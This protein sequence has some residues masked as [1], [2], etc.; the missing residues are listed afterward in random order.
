MDPTSLSNAQLPTLIT[1][2]MGLSLALRKQ[3]SPFLDKL[4]IELRRL[5]YRY[6]LFNPILGTKEGLAVSRY[7]LFPAILRTCKQINTEGREV[8]Y[9]D[10]AFFAS[11]NVANHNRYTSGFFHSCPL[12][13]LGGGN[14]RGNSIPPGIADAFRSVRHWKILLTRVHGDEAILDPDMDLA[15]FAR[16]IR[17]AEP[18]SLE[19]IVVPLLVERCCSTQAKSIDD[20]LRTLHIVRNVG[21]ISIRGATQ[22]DIPSS[23]FGMFNWPARVDINALR[24][25][26]DMPSLILQAQITIL[27]T[28]NSQ[29]DF[30]FM[31]FKQLLRYAKA[32][33]YLDE[34]KAQMAGQP[35]EF[36]PVCHEDE[37]NHRPIGINPYVDYQVM[38][39]VEQALRH[40]KAAAAQNDVMGF[41]TY[42]AIVFN[43]FE[44]QY[45]TIAASFANLRA[46]IG[47]EK[48]AGG[49][50]DPMDPFMRL[51]PSGDD[52]MLR[53][54]LRA[55][56]LL[57]HYKN[58]FER[59][60]PV[61]V[62]VNKEVCQVKLESVKRCFPREMFLENMNRHH[63]IGL[64]VHI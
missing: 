60:C 43:Y 56:V 27:V 4:P 39:P 38:H 8:L 61:E 28:G 30:P 26:S 63:A 44:R 25:P 13:A 19:L 37:Y 23:L 6:L 2:L 22:D 58:S 34:F 10:N 16:L 41:K 47:S 54:M 1:A 52:R 14:C 17:Q 18:T 15:H 11:F 9:S 48:R 20:V 21:E 50:L 36:N 55:K 64:P 35:D 51:S 24:S 5:V 3:P 57:V 33:E 59:Q 46:V 62:Q 32:F 29:V 45:Q 53:K 31:M 40:A 12:T 7:D 49:V 42:R